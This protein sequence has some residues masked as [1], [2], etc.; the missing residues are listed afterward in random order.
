MKLLKGSI[1]MIRGAAAIGSMAKLA[2]GAT[3]A[4][5]AVGGA[6]EKIQGATTA[7]KTLTK[8]QVANRQALSQ[9]GS[10]LMI[11]GTLAFGAYQAGKKYWE[12][13]KRKQREVRRAVVESTKA[14]SASLSMAKALMKATAKTMESEINNAKN[15]A[16]AAQ[17]L[18]DKYTLKIAKMKGEVANAFRELQKQQAADPNSKKTI[19]AQK[20]HLLLSAKFKAVA[21]AQ[22][23]AEAMLAR[24]R[25]K[26]A[27]GDERTM[28]A[29]QIIAQ[30]TAKFEALVS[31]RKQWFKAQQVKAEDISNAKDKKA[32]MDSAKRRNMEMLLSN[33]RFR[34]QTAHMAVR[35]KLAGKDILHRKGQQKK[36]EKLTEASRANRAA[37]THQFF[38]GIS[39]RWFKAAKGGYI[40]KGMMSKKGLDR[41]GAFARVFR[42]TMGIDEA[43]GDKAFLTKIQSAGKQF[44]GKGKGF[45]AAPGGQYSWSPTKQKGAGAE[46]EN[47]LTRGLFNLVEKAGTQWVKRDKMVVNVNLDGKTMATIVTNHQ[48]KSTKEND[49]TGAVTATTG[50][51]GGG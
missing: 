13:Q 47:F 48:N 32:F 29:R 21:K 9:L 36:L 10:G 14:Y 16:A 25:I 33:R 28:L 12:D 6:T 4:A 5:S 11:F 24:H 3:A 44:A 22:M 18:V 49:G 35:Y 50:V 40:P 41:F 30:R 42:S 8:A 31:D 26:N 2:T 23:D 1:M 17:K 27:K 15:T 37:A 20:K 38:E 45:A 51:Q 7:T 43:G 19:E 34:Q 39:P 46:G